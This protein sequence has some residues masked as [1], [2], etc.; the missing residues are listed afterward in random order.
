ESV[1]FARQKPRGLSK[2][3]TSAHDRT[4]SGLAAERR[5]GLINT[6]GVSAQA[7]V[8]GGLRARGAAAD[9]Y[10]RF[11]CGRGRYGQF[12]LTDAGGVDR[13]VGW[14]VA[15]E[16]RDAFCAGDAP[17]SLMQAALL[18]LEQELRIRV[19]TAGNA[20]EV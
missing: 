16:K 13:T 3:L 15:A 11:R 5:R 2:V 19:Q 20:D 9:D 17:A 6:D 4:G 8:A 1:H 12:Q 7:S 10:H 18:S 14:L